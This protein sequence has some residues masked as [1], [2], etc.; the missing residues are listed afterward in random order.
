MGINI[1]VS[2][3]K[4]VCCISL[5]RFVVR[6]RDVCLLLEYIFFVIVIIIF[7]VNWLIFCFVGIVF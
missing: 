4:V 5:S 3:I 7:L 2:Y 6:G 1:Y